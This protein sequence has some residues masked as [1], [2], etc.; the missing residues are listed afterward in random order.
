MKKNTEN[1]K[2]LV[3][4]TSAIVVAVIIMAITLSLSYTG[5]SA[6]FNVLDL[7]HKEKTLSSAEACAN[8]ASLKIVADG[9]YQ[10]DENVPVGDLSCEILP[11]TKEN[12][13]ITIRT[14][15]VFPENTPSSPVTNLVVVLEETSFE[16]ISWEE[17]PN[18]L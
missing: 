17:V 6:R 7:G 2:G 3:A 15:A 12:G 10:G 4:L 11:V 1:Q 14:R 5:F 8:V 18:H 13:E 9:G 16:T